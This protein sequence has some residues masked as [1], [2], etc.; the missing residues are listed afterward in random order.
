[1]QYKFKVQKASGEIE[2]GVREAVDKLA[3]SHELRKDGLTVIS[4]EESGKSGGKHFELPALFG[5][6][7]M[8]DKIIFARNLGSMIKAGLSVNRSLGVMERQTKNKKMKKML[9]ALSDSVSRGVTLSDSMKNFP[10]IFSPIFVFMVKAGEESGTLADSLQVVANQ[11]DRSYFLQKKIKGA[12]VY[13]AIILGVMAAIGV[14]MLVFIV[15]TLTATFRD[16]KVDLPLSTRFVIFASDLFKNHIL[17]ILIALVLAALA[18]MGIRKTVSGKRVIDFLILHTPIVGGLARE[19][20]SAHTARTLSS[21]LSSGVDIVVA[22]HITADVL[23]NSYYKKV[24]ARAEADIQKGKQ[25]SSIF[26]EEEKL[27]P[28]FVAE[29]VSVGEETGKLPD[30]LM[31]V[32]KF[33]ENEVEQKTKDMS[34]IIE[35][36]LMVFIGIVVGFFAIAMMTPTYSL[37]NN[38]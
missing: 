33:Y 34:T 7:N 35:P 37:V 31:E 10:D 36:F 9:T 22:T 4:I 15:P 14:L 12:M 19:S 13:P 18:L 21:L 23:Q 3:L 26:E 2:E 8:H 16:L 27:Y 5:R 32:A 30:M 24:L 11:L 29:M 6:I 28:V 1:M 17:L 38:F 25:M 20:N